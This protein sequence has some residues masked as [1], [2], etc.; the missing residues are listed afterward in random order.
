MRGELNWIQIKWRQASIERAVLCVERRCKSSALRREALYPIKGK[1]KRREPLCKNQV[2]MRR[3]ERKH[4]QLNGLK[5]RETP[6][7]TCASAL[8]LIDYLLFARCRSICC[9]TFYSILRLHPQH[10]YIYEKI[11]ADLCVLV[12]QSGWA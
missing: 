1:I 7:S 3:R 2:G 9:D 12:A 5:V 10:K 8:F 11:G 6:G 4:V